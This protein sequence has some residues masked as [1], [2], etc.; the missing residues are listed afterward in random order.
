MVSPAAHLTRRE[1]Q[2]C[3][4]VVRGYTNKEI[5]MSLGISHRTVEDHRR[6]IMAKYKVRNAVEL[7]RAVYGL[8]GGRGVAR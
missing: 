7:V 6:Y 2:I 5:G 4:R 3:D 8:A 1:Q